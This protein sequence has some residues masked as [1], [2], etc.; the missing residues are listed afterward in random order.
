MP[1]TYLLSITNSVRLR[2]EGFGIPIVALVTRIYAY[3]TL[4][5]E[6]ITSWDKDGGFFVAHR[7]I[8]ALRVILVV[9][10]YIGF[11]ALFAIGNM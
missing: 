5:K 7:E 1:A 9:V 3:N 6:G 4:T 8:G 2:G 10:L 11:A